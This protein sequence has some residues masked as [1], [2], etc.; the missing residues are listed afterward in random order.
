M[1]HWTGGTPTE[2]G[3][4]AH[5]EFG[6]YAVFPSNFF[7]AHLAPF[8]YGG[9]RDAYVMN[10][11]NRH[12][13]ADRSIGWVTAVMPYYSINHNIDP[14]GLD[15]SIAYS[16]FFLQD[17]LRGIYGFDGVICTDWGV[18]NTRGF[19]PSV[20][21]L[22]RAQRSEALIYAGV[23]Q[24][25]GANIT[26]FIVQAFNDS[27]A[28]PY[29][30]ES[31]AAFLDAMQV[32][33]S[34]LL[35]NIFI[36]GLFE[37]PYT[38]PVYA[39]D[40]GNNADNHA[41]GYD[42][43][44]RANVL[45]KNSDNLLPLDTGTKV[46]VPRNASG[47]P[48][49]VQVE[50][51]GNFVMV[52]DPAQAD[53][54][55]VPI[56][57][58]F[59]SSA[60][61]G[62]G[63]NDAAG[64]VPMVN[65]YS[66]YTAVN[67]RPVSIAGDW[68]NLNVQPLNLSFGNRT[69]NRS[70]R[71]FTSRAQNLSQLHL[72]LD[73]AEA[74]GPDTPIITVMNTDNP[75]V[76][77]EINAVS[78]A[79]IL[80]FASTDSAVL[81]IISGNHAPSGLLPFQMPASMTVV[82]MQNE[83]QPR[84]FVGDEIFKDE[85]GNVYDFAFGLTWDDSGR[86]IQ[87]E[88]ERTTRFG[89]PAIQFL[90]ELDSSIPPSGLA[91]VSN[92]D[93]DVIP[94]GIVGEEYTATIES[95]PGSE[96]ELVGII[97][98]V[99]LANDFSN[100]ANPIYMGSTPIINTVNP[101]TAFGLTGTANVAAG[102]FTISGIPTAVTSS[103][104]TDFGRGPSGTT[105]RVDNPDVIA[106]SASG[107][108][109]LQLLFN[110][111]TPGLSERQNY[112]ITLVITEEED[113]YLTLPDPNEL[114]VELTLS[115]RQ[116]ESNWT[117]ESWSA[118]AAARKAAEDFFV[119]MISALPTQPTRIAY[120]TRASRDEIIANLETLLEENG[121]NIEAAQ[122]VI[123][124]LVDDLA[125]A[126]EAL[127][128]FDAIPFVPIQTIATAS[129]LIL[130]QTIT[131][132]QG[133]ARRRVNETL[134]IYTNTSYLALQ[135]A[136]LASQKVA[137]DPNATQANIDAAQ[138]TLQEAQNALVSL[139]DINV[140]T[141]FNDINT[142]AHAWM[143]PY[144]TYVYAN[145]LMVGTGAGSFSPNRVLTRAEAAQMLFNMAGAPETVGN[146]NIFNDVPANHWGARAIAW[147]AS[148]QIILGNGKGDFSPENRITREDYAVMLYRY[149]QKHGFDVVVPGD[150]RSNALDI[151]TVS[152][153]ARNAMIWANYGKL[154]TGIGTGQLL[155]QGFT[156]RSASAAILTRFMETVYFE[157]ER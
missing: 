53:V 3:R 91:E 29:L 98:G 154:I 152:P 104:P 130:N 100:P 151:N 145:N 120:P 89:V 30:F 31:Q 146:R 128:R 147:A 150:F 71:N 36:T 132:A 7:E 85:D 57:S 135:D 141:I 54:A 121:G 58:P 153:W 127:V 10:G 76:M 40:L 110:V 106:E 65:Q 114:S 34:Y 133:V 24:F 9:L 15:R 134:P 73:V 131:L 49:F 148:E 25:G 6:A 52:D 124:G 136:I 116:Q 95:T 113:A 75:T 105:R 123:D 8:V 78:D 144:I 117:I 62:G 143:R 140:T 35:H 4:D 74:V 60:D 77:T 45:L 19:G 38:C 139:A 94:W 2:G 119:E 90:N 72:L 55:I 103:T 26:Q 107:E 84:K 69:L 59:L 122:A 48:M 1:K 156:Q 67:A 20:D 96:I 43:Q 32:S 70:Y 39:W 23:N 102:T 79:V 137:A 88:D 18:D 50:Q 82:E 118:F 44:I 63:W 12:Y 138:R 80:R 21:M 66:Q 112:R 86:T 28:N 157:Q 83:D 93:T 99:A 16:E 42:A 68:R 125:T 87:I 111:N 46:Y 149:A 33:V 115:S 64:Y 92:I 37:N 155:P 41:A 27:A 81:Q 101:L 22:T 14:T 129:P 142:A 13:M 11:E 51:F 47:N 17:M 5:S 109:G 61:F 126:R 108:L 56:N 97:T